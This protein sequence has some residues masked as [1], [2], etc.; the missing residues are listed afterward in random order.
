MTFMGGW[1]DHTEKVKPEE[2]G[3]QATCTPAESVPAQR[4]QPWPR[5]RGGRHEWQ[6]GVEGE[7]RSNW[8][9]VMR[10]LVRNLGLTPR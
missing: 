6:V 9:L 2:A 1:E 3:E 4:G 7:D 5:P 8:R 10:D